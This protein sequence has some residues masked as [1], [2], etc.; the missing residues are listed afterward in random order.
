MLS[1]GSSGPPIAGDVTN[2]PSKTPVEVLNER[3]DTL[4]CLLLILVVSAI[5]IDRSIGLLDRL[6]EQVLA[7][8]PIGSPAPDWP[9]RPPVWPPTRLVAD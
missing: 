3:A 4:L 5:V 2:R 9:R 8:P 7:P 1:T 6:L